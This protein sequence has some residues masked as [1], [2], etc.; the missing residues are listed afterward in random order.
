MRYGCLW[1]KHSRD[2]AHKREAVVH[3]WVCARMCSFPRVYAETRFSSSIVACRVA[4][5]CGWSSGPSDAQGGPEPRIPTLAN[6]HCP[7]RV[8]G[9]DQRVPTRE[10][11][12]ELLHQCLPREGERRSNTRSGG[13]RPTRPQP[14]GTPWSTA[15]PD[16]RLER[17]CV[18]QWFV[19]SAFRKDGARKG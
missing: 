4:T 14:K 12:G 11:S 1:H 3:S 10:T 8:R 7:A 13:R 6:R 2:I 15:P 18:C 19:S 17:L 16:P 9:E 5:T